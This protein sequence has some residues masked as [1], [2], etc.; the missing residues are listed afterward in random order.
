MQ[1]LIHKNVEVITGDI[2]YEGILIEVGERDVQLQ[3]R[4]GWIVVPLERILDIREV[5]REE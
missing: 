3:G 1:H 5:D 2:T 4:S